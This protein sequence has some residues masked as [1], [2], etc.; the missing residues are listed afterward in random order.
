[1]LIRVCR[2]YGDQRSG[3]ISNRIDIDRTHYPAA[4]FSRFMT[5]DGTLDVSKKS[6]GVVNYRLAFDLANWSPGFD[7]RAHE[8]ELFALAA[9]MN[10]A[11]AMGTVLN[12]VKSTDFSK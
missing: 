11:R 4:G 7:W 2:S 3:R 8:C 10:S 12:T 5:R 9:K 6:E 1:M